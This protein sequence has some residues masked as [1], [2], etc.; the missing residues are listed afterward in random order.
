MQIQGTLITEAATAA[1]QVIARNLMEHGLAAS[2]DG[3]PQVW[4]RDTVITFLGAA[5]TGD[6][7]ILD[8]FRRSL[9]ELASAQDRFGQMPLL[10]WKKRNFTEYG[11]I[12]ANPWFVIGAAYYARL[13]NDPAWTR[14]MAPTVINALDWCEAQDRTK[15][16]LMLAGE[17]ADWAD[18]M[19]QHGHVLF[20][21]ILYA[22]AL[23]CGAEMVGAAFP[24]EAER[25]RQR[26]GIVSR[27]IQ[28]LF[29][30]KL[31]DECDDPTHHQVRRLASVTLR[32]RPYFLPWVD[33]F[34]FG[35]RFDT[36]ANLLAVLTGVADPAQA[37]AI[38]QFI[39][40][41][42]LHR[43]HPVQVLY[44][45]IHPGETEWRD[46]FL[47][48]NLNLPHQYH[49]G[50]IWP[51]VGALY[52]AALAQVGRQQ[53][54]EEELHS[55]AQALRAGEEPWECNEWLHGQSGQPMGKRFQAWSAGM[56]LYAL[57]AVQFGEVPGLSGLAA[58]TSWSCD[59]LP[60]NIL[61]GNLTGPS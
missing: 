41:V 43:P 37:G 16:G 10:T 33:L 30:V 6:E 12:D 11:S 42:G 5:L 34:T 29:W 3:Y 15:I 8:G 36:T 59:D 48:Y 35:S 56:F 18:L 32:G 1:R 9:D 58:P 27:A 21:N 4:T 51:W 2:V 60:E 28:E 13:V 57:H 49:N 38:L 46:Y 26:A 22:R 47:V 31:P 23:I 17:C 52:V 55:L 20:P 7:K 54:A 53:R 39:E 25:L 40:Q 14:R 19:P 50:G 61:A 45:P 24:V 44:P